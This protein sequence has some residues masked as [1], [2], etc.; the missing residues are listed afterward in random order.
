MFLNIYYKI[1]KKLEAH[2]LILL[3]RNLI[4]QVG[5]MCY[6]FQYL[7]LYLRLKECNIEP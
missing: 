5:A 3:K 2:K 7:Q 1:Y 4:F 6:E